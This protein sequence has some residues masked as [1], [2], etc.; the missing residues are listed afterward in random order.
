[1]LA[2]LC[3]RRGEL[4][5]IV[6]NS[7]DVSGPFE[8]A[9]GAYRSAYHPGRTA[10]YAAVRWRTMHR[11]PRQEATNRMSMAWNRSPYDTITLVRAEAD[12]VPGAAV[13][14]LVLC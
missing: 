7:S 13:R 3:R 1:V 4:L 5:C 6:C 10:A 2:A 12:T 8:L 11:L 9:A 14:F